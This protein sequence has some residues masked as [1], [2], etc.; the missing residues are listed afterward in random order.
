MPGIGVP[1][2]APERILDEQPDYVLLLSWN[3]KDEI[4]KQQ[5]VYLE[6]GGTFIV[7]IPAPTFVGGSSNEPPG[8]G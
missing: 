5:H 4:L 3:F 8:N 6:A 2:V 7:P 1:I